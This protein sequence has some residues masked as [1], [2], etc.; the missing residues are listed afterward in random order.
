M[1][2][3]RERLH[4]TAT[5]PVYGRDEL[6]SRLATWACNQQEPIVTYLHGIP[7][8]GK[9]TV[10]AAL[11]SRVRAAGGR[12]L[13]FDCGAIE[14]T[15]ATALAAIAAATRLPIATTA[16]LVALSGRGHLLLVLDD[17][18]TWR[19]LDS[20]VRREFLPALPADVR[21]LIAGRDRPSGPWR[22]TPEWRHA[23]HP[24]EL[25]PLDDTAALAFLQAAGL[26]ADEARRVQQVACGHPLA[27]ALAITGFTDEARRPIDAAALG[28]LISE[29][30]A[31]F[32]AATPDRLARNA[33]EAASVT[34]RTTRSLLSALLS[35]DDAQDAYDRLCRL[36]FVREGWDGLSVHDA[37][38]AAVAMRLQSAD[39]RHYLQ[40][41]RAAWR[42]LQA[43]SWEAADS[44][45]WRYTADILYLLQHPVLREAFFPAGE[46]PV[47]V[48]P[49]TPKD[50]PTIL[51]LELR[52]SGDESAAIL[53]RWLDL[54]PQAFCVARD[55]DGVIVGYHCS[56]TS[57]HLHPDLA[58]HDPILAHLLQ[59]LAASPAPE[60]PAFILRRWVS[61]DEGDHPGDVQAA[62]WMD[63]KREYLARR[64][65]LGHIYVCTPESEFYMPFLD[66]LGFE[67]LTESDIMLDGRTYGVLRNR[68]GLGSVDGWLTRIVGAEL[69]VDSQ[70]VLD[71]RARQLVIR[72]HRFPLTPLEF[73][74]MRELTHQQG[75]AVTR[76]DLVQAVWGYAYTG[77]SNVEAVVI[78]GLRAKLGDHAPLI[79][80]VRGVGYR[81]KAL[82]P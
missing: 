71:E 58:A 51:D 60:E 73:G 36:P 10:A 77:E 53:R 65:R 82:P 8:I 48:D 11:A 46:S 35:P 41:R 81:L 31:V 40:L 64:P 38:K 4:A 12:A 63:C 59:D 49:A 57:D 42:Q 45:Q 52:A 54:Q 75:E 62:C 39:P 16:D 29:L 3:V 44:D 28:G 70:V 61:R 34:R 27:L 32:M 6:I 5:R 17:Y 23:C 30:A 9:S 80:T 7:G 24:V 15:Q 67:R 79:E 72:G 21:I 43:E 76:A 22:F 74:V 78:R 69:G 19:L 14:P 68:L 25:E 20:W 33:L 18:D 50:H 13:E 56:T 55:R 26:R 1:E 66:Q 47:V 2:T 37:V